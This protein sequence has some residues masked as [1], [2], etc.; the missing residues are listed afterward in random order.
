M[1]FFRALILFDIL[2]MCFFADFF[3]SCVICAL[4][5]AHLNWT[6]LVLGLLRVK[7]CCSKVIW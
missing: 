4:K 3:I 7:S 5:E 6:S 2:P 1:S